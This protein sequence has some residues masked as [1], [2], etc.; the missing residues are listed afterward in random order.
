MF[1]CG[2]GG[3]EERGAGQNGREAGQGRREGGQQSRGQGYEGVLAGGVERSV[4]G[5]PLGFSETATELRSRRQVNIKFSKR[6]RESILLE[7]T[8]SAEARGQENCGEL[9][10]SGANGDPAK[11]ALCRHLISKAV[12]VN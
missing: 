11:P 7:G 5:G 8:A 3:P 10:G 2:G 4:L 6:G 9:L 12:F 1:E